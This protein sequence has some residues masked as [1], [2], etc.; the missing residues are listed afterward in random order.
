MFSGVVQILFYGSFESSENNSNVFCKASQS[1]VENG[2]IDSF[3]SKLGEK[4]THTHTNYGVFVFV[5]NLKAA[6]LVPF[7]DKL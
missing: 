5:S 1:K 7:L 2:I 4:T 6:T 3:N